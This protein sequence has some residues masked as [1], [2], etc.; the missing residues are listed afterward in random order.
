MTRWYFWTPGVA[1]R[2]VPKDLLIPWK[3]ASRFTVCVNLQHHDTAF[4]AT[5]IPKTVTFYL[6]LKKSPS[7]RTFGN[8]RVS[9]VLGSPFKSTITL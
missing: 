2:P 1:T 4:K 5:F 3:P 8:S 7:P 6:C 9:K